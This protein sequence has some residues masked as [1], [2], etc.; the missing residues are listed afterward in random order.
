MFVASLLRRGMIDKMLRHPEKFAAARQLFLAIAIAQKAV[1]RYGVRFQ[2]K[3]TL[4]CRSRDVSGIRL[5][6]MTGSLPGRTIMSASSDTCDCP[7]SGTGW[8]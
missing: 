3:P 4:L 5:T 1:P 8:R 7:E 2:Q 6:D